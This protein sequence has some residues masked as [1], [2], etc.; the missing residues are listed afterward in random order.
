MAGRISL[1]F[2]LTL[3]F[4]NAQSGTYFI[5]ENTV[6]A[7]YSSWVISYSVDLSPY[8]VHLSGILSEIYGFQDAVKDLLKTSKGSLVN[9]S[10]A[11]ELRRIRTQI[12]IVL[13]NEAQ[14]FLEEFNGIHD[15]LQTI[16][17]LSI[18]P[19]DR[20]KRSIL[21]AVGNLMS[22]LFGVSTE[23][24]V[25]R[26]RKSIINLQHVNDQVVHVVSDSL[27]L[28][29]KSNEEIRINRNALRKIT[30]ATSA[31]QREFQNIW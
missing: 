22:F 18:S 26:L 21:P 9:N 6:Y 16:K 3:P 5:Y 23:E 13:Q 30:N 24:N 1:F 17:T 11:N 27:T 25:N 8:E 10:R 2:L 7:S 28:I 19:H 15:T 12:N 14:Q 20:P 31:I 4:V 29:N